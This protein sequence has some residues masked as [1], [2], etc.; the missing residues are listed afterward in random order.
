MDV[1]KILMDNYDYNEPIILKDV[2]ID[3][4]SYE[5][6]RQI[7][8]RLVK[9]GK[10]ERYEQGVYYIPKVTPFGKSKIAAK[11]IYERKFITDGKNIYGFYSGL[12]LL[13]AIGLTTQVPN[14]IEIITNKESSRRR[15]ILVG[16]QRLRL[17]RARIVITSGNANILQLLELI[18][19]LDTSKLSDNQKRILINFIRSQSVKLNDIL[20]YINYYPNKVS[21]KLMERLVINELTS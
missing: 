17:R 6:I 20:P 1:M 2:K 7:F 15:E 9:S 18:N 3:G 13:N 14:T 11:K 4:V 8:S 5:N 19:T 21:K 16:N 12:M 10:L